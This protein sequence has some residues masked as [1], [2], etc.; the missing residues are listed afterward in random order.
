MRLSLTLALVCLA[1][2][3]SNLVFASDRTDV[4]L[5]RYAGVQG[6]DAVR[7]FDQFQH[8]LSI[9]LRNLSQ[10]LINDVPEIE[11]LKLKRIFENQSDDL[12]NPVDWF[13][14]LEM[15]LQ[16]WTQEA[17]TLAMLS[18]RIGH[19]VQDL[20]LE[21]VS[22]MFWGDIGE[23]PSE[24]SIAIRLPLRGFHYDDS[25]D[26]H[27]AAVL[28]AYAMHLSSECDQN[29]R[30]I[31]LL[32]AARQHASAVIGDG[33]TFGDQLFDRIVRALQRLRQSPCDGS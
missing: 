26:S 18:G 6:N 28:F 10:S 3:W 14:S 21:I 25:R 2:P 19:Q 1:I 22:R 12:A 27:A 31:R 32:S 17:H 24:M 23:N 15:E 13:Q 20:G 8:S 16:Y 29:S 11:R 9:Q 4:H 7:A 5:F 33:T 30:R